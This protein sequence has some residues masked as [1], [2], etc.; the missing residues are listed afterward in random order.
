MHGMN[1]IISL[2]H[3]HRGRSHLPASGNS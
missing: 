3:G 1:H 2:V